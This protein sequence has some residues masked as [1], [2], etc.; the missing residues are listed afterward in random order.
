MEAKEKLQLRLLRMMSDKLSDEQLKTLKDSMP[1]VMYD[2]GIT[3]IN[4]TEL[5]QYEGGKT[6]QL[7]KYYTVS[8][9]A[10]NTSK[11]TIMQYVRVA[12][13]LCDSISKAWGWY[14]C[15]IQTSRTR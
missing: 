11:E 6:E 15:Y 10:S 4:D 5:T 9:L 12:K 7:I 13:Q 2:Y 1:A 14:R 3:E 8:K